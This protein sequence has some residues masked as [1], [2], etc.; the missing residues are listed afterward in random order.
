MSRVNTNIEWTTIPRDEYLRMLDRHRPFWA[1][2]MEFVFVNK[3]RSVIEA[4]CGVGALSYSV[5]EYMG[6]D[7]NGEVLRDNELFYR[8]G[9]WVKSDWMDMDLR[10]LA[11]D[12]FLSASLIQHCK[13]FETFM[14]RVVVLPVSYAV[15]TFHKG[16]RDEEVIQVDRKSVFFDN[17]YSRADVEAWLASNLG[18]VR[19]SLFDIPVSRRKRQHRMESV[20]VI[21]RTGT[22]QLDMWSKR[23]L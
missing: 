19:W 11:A 10:V 5:D 15:V 22:A 20:L 12:L 8:R 3:V 4:G 6:I 13:S 1:A 9:V 14:E 23:D 21:D 18:S 2:M 16:L 7:T 17:L